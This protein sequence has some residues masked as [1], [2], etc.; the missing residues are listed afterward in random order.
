MNYF[1][2]GTNEKHYREVVKNPLFNELVS[3]MS[4]QTE[5]RLILRQLHAQFPEKN[6]EKFLDKL[7]SLGIVVRENRQYTLGFPIYKETVAV[8]KLS[9]ML[10]EIVKNET[11]ENQEGYLGE[12]VWN[13]LFPAADYFYGV[14][15]E[16][17]FYTKSEVGN[18]DLQFVSLALTDKPIT[19]PDYFSFIRQQKGLPE[20]FQGLHQLIGDV[21]EV[22]FFNQVEMVLEKVEKGRLRTSRRNIFLESLEKTGVVEV[23]DEV[24]VLWPTIDYKLIEKMPTEKLTHWLTGI[25][26]S[27]AEEHDYLLKCVFKELL[28]VLGISALYYIKK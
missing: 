27:S 4:E 13:K 14:V 20:T 11:M 16:T 23:G 24:R 21:N 7:I 15:V 17:D 22:Y 26:A 2:Q 6:F 28:K 1:Y 19:L 10:A 5:Q 12:I 25:P 18:E 9:Q 3:Y 8:N